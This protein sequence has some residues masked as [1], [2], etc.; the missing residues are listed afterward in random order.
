MV[1]SHVFSPQNKME[2]SS[3]MLQGKVVVS[4]REGK[5]GSLWDHLQTCYSQTEE[6]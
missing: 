5:K 6:Q 3:V 2:Y 4:E 1:D